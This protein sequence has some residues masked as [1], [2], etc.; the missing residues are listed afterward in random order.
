MHPCTP[1]HT[2][3]LLEPQL[4]LRCHFLGS[5]EEEAGIPAQNTNG[6][7]LQ[8][9]PTGSTFQTSSPGAAETPSCRVPHVH[10]G[11]AGSK[12]PAASHQQEVLTAFQ[13]AGRERE[14]GGPVPNHHT[15]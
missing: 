2:L 15:S 10:V 14:R 8:S 12:S 9:S 4:G 5:R 6:A 11:E 13:T 3:T 1:P 7:V